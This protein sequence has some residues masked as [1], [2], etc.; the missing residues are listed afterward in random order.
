MR[1]GMALQLLLRNMQIQPDY[2]HYDA[3]SNH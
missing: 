3:R 2:D 1:V